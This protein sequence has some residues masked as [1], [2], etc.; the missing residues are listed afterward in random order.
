MIPSGAINV[1]T[2]W[3]LIPS[4][5]KPTCIVAGPEIV[6]APLVVKVPATSGNP[7]KSNVAVMVTGVGVEADVEG[8]EPMVKRAIAHSA[9]AAAKNLLCRII[10]ILC[11]R[12][13]FIFFIILIFPFVVLAFFDFS[14]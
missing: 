6:R 4:V 9:I 1:T 2:Q 11:R 3:A 5:L 14:P 8:T 7:E 13:V 12:S 10:S